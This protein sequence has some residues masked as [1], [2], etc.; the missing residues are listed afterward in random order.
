MVFE[1][2][3]GASSFPGRARKA[4]EELVRSKVI[5]Q[6]IEIGSPDDAA[7][8]ASFDYVFGGRGIFLGNRTRELPDRLM[9]AVRDSVSG[10]LRDYFRRGRA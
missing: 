7:A 5:V 4:V 10:V 6:A 9:K 3:D 2:T 8:R 1:V